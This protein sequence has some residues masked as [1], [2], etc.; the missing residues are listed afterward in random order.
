[1]DQDNRP[2]L[3]IDCGQIGLKKAE[4]L[5]KKLKNK[6]IIIVKPTQ[7]EVKNY[8]Q[9]ADK[10][11]DSETNPVKYLVFESSF[12]ERIAESLDRKNE[13]TFYDLNENAIGIINGD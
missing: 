13:N 4:A 3:W 12:V 7:A 9:V 10:K 2:A 1:L 5:M 6:R 11:T 8:K